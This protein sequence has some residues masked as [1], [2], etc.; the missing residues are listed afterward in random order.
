[1]SVTTSVVRERHKLIN[2]NDFTEDEKLLHGTMATNQ[3]HLR[4]CRLPSAGAN[5]SQHPQVKE[6]R[7]GCDT[8][9]A[10]T[11]PFGVRVSTNVPNVPV[12]L[13]PVHRQLFE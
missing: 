8:I 7:P 11:V 2:L 6:L 9:C 13:K 3:D 4:S 12:L 5:V 1:M 10:S